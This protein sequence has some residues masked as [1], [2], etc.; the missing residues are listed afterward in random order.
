V[1]G[2]LKSEKRDVDLK[3]KVSKR[4]LNNKKCQPREIKVFFVLG[5]NLKSFTFVRNLLPYK[6]DEFILKYKK[7]FTYLSKSLKLKTKIA[8]A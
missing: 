7:S 5:E 8:F 1:F 4:P 6:I 3:F 2:E